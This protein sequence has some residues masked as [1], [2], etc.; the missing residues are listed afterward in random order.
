[1]AT[2]CLRCC[3]YVS[4]TSAA[5]GC[6]NARWSHTSASTSHGDEHDAVGAW[7]SRSWSS[8][9]FENA[10]Q[11]CGDVVEH[12]DVKRQLLVAP[13]HVLCDREQLEQHLGR[14]GRRGE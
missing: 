4:T 8:R 3:A 1:M 11:Q 7:Y 10:P 13:L 6:P 12:P 2:S 5:S 14:C 9:A